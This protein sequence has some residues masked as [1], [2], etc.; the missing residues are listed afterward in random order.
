MSTPLAYNGIEEYSNPK[1]VI[2]NAKKYLGKDVDIYLSN[3]KGKKYMIFNP[4][5]QNMVHFGAY[6]MEDFTYHKDEIRRQNYL[7]RATNIRGNWKTNKYSPNNL[8]INLLWN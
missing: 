4:N 1:I 2:K 7:K 8:S 5:T 3:R 6:G